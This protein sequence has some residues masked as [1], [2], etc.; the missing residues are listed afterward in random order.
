[1]RPL[2]PA[3][4]EEFRDQLETNAGCRG[5]ERV[6]ERSASAGLSSGVSP[7]STREPWKVRA[8]E[9]HAPVAVWWKRDGRGGLGLRWGEERGVDRT[10]RDG[11]QE[12]DSAWGAGP[13][14]P[15]F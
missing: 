8:G 11:V 3:E 6:L 9:G 12:A 1:M 2:E 10:G 14:S 13:G 4:E 5:G 7:E 15:R